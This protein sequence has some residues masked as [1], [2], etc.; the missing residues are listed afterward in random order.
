MSRLPEAALDA[1]VPAWM[2]AE[3]PFRE[4]RYL[5]RDISWQDWLALPAAARPDVG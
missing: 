2:A 5:G 3:W 4:P 1:L